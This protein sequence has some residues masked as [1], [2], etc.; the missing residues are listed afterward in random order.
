MSV[1]GTNKFVIEGSKGKELHGKIMAAVERCKEFSTPVTEFYE[2]ENMYVTHEYEIGEFKGKRYSI[3]KKLWYDR[4]TTYFIGVYDGDKRCAISR[5]RLDQVRYEDGALHL[6]EEWI[7]NIGAFDMYFADRRLWR[8]CNFYYYEWDEGCWAGV[9]NDTDEKYFKKSCNITGIRIPELEAPP[10]L[11][12]FDEWE[13]FDEWEYFHKQ[14]REYEEKYNPKD[15]DEWTFEKQLEFCEAHKE[16]IIYEATKIVDC[17][18][19][20]GIQ[21]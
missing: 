8:E 5:F 10:E 7:N 18:T 17:E 21:E 4:K 13:E 14:E 1:E 15:F 2:D 11:E 12:N 20:W 16:I 6:T 9:T 3:F 19:Y